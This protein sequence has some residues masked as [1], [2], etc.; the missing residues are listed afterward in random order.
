MRMKSEDF[1]QEEYVHFQLREA[2]RISKLKGQA[3]LTGPLLF[4]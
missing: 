4:L 3:Q 1:C 2:Q